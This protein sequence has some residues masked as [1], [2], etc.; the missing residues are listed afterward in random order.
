MNYIISS[1]LL[2]ISVLV[3]NHPFSIGEKLLYNVKFNIIPSGE[4]VLEVLG[5]DTI[6]GNP[7]YH[8]RFSAQTNST[9]DRLYKVRD[10]VDIWMDEQ[11]LVTHKLIKKIREGKYH[12][13]SSTIINYSDSSAITNNDTVKITGE[14][15]DPYSLFFYLRT[16]QLEDGA[17]LEFDSFEKN[18]PTPFNLAVTGEETVKTD[19]GLFSCLVVRPFRKGKTLLKNEGDMQIWFSHDERRLPVQIQIKMKYGLMI[20]KLKEV[21]VR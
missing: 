17:T 14:I 6:N 21:T 20:L 13:K 15:R 4:A 12:K 10:Q 5:R 8:A 19:A 2:I 3:A 18:E 11:N 16:L 9:L 1:I 7:T